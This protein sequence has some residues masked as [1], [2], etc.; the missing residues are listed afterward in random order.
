MRC[1]ASKH[2]ALLCDCPAG[3]AVTTQLASFSGL[4]RQLRAVLASAEHDARSE[5]LLEPADWLLDRMFGQPACDRSAC[6]Y[7]PTSRVQLYKVVKTV[8]AHSSE[9]AGRWMRSKAGVEP[10]SVGLYT[11]HPNLARLMT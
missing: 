4:E 11:C 10:A 2:C 9:Q 1:W 8:S 3:D 5:L 6:G 7:T